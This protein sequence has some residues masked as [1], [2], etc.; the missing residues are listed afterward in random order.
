MVLAWPSEKMGVSPILWRN[1][2][3][4][5]FIF[6]ERPPEP[7]EIANHSWHGFMAPHGRSS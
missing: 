7:R 1:V 5:E 2:K 3:R 4:Y 6:E